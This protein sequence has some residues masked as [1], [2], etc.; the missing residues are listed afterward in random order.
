MKEKDWF[1]EEVLKLSERNKL[2]IILRYAEH[3]A[4]LKSFKLITLS[5]EMHVGKEDQSEKK[6][7]TDE[8]IDEQQFRK[9]QQYFEKSEKRRPRSSIFSK[10]KSMIDKLR[11]TK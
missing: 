7:I 10:G 8:E 9:S 3:A 2:N 5:L 4:K 6:A 11:D 1:T